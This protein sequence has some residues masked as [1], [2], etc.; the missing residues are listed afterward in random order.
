MH[1]TQHV[2][3]TGLPGSGK[4]RLKQILVDQ[5]GFNAQHI[6]V[7]SDCLT[8]I[9]PPDNLKIDVVWCVIDIR[10]TLSAVQDKAVELHLQ[11]LVKKSNAVVFTFS[12]SA[13]LD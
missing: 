4:H 2:Y 8:S 5:T 6:S 13:D 11:W 3:L 10:S 12:E 7:D 9:K 1:Q